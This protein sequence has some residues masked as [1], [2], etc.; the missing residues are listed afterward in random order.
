MAIYFISDFHLGEG[1][2]KQERAKLTRFDLFLERTGDDLEH[3][4]I[5]GD[6]FDFWFEYKHLIPKRH[7]QILFKL[8]SLVDAGI[9]VSYV[10]GNHD[11]WMGD[12]LPQEMKIDLHRDLME[13]DTPRGK[14]LAMHG[15]GLAKSDWKYRLLKSILRNRLC[16]ALYKL[17]PPTLAFNLAHRTSRKSREHTSQRHPNSFLE[18]DV[19]YAQRRFAEGYHAFICG[20]TNHPDIS[21]IGDNYYVNTGDWIENFSYVRYDD[22]KFEL[23][24]LADSN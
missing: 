10:A 9:P 2:E 21:P 6:L 18:E 8:R 19:A 24:Y 14:I 22:G 23:G 12:F 1:L 4:I 11:H 3:L 7:L 16:I 13:I 17:L 20:H 15:D 5:L